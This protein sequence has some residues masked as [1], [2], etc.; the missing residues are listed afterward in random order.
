[1]FKILYK[2]IKKQFIFLKL[3]DIILRNEFI[4]EI[5]ILVMKKRLCILFGG[6][7]TEYEIS[8]RSAYSVITNVDT[9][10]YDIILVG[11]TRNGKWCLYQGDYEKI[12]NDSWFSPDLPT[13]SV[14]HGNKE[15]AFIVEKSDSTYE[16][17]YFDVIFPV[18]HGKNGEDGTIQGLFELAAI[19]YAG[20][21]IIASSVG[22]DKTF[23]KI[24]FKHAGIDQADWVEIAKHEYDNLN[25]KITEIETKLGYP[26]FIK[27]ANAGSSIGI[28]KAYNKDQLIEAI[29]EAFRFDRKILV[30]EL[31]TGHEVECA[32]LGNRGH[33]KA[34]CVGEIVASKDFYTYD[35]KY[36]S[37]STSEIVIPAN[38]E[39]KYAEIVRENAIKAFES[40]DGKGLSRVDFFVDEKKGRVC[41]N[42]INT[43][44]GFTSIS[45]YPKL[46]VESGLT[47]S[48]LLNEIIDIALQE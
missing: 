11:I 39:S 22:M 23:T 40:L 19:K 20:V 28:G 34:S 29:D 33:I 27:P 25:V 26:V 8:L 14:L 13:V 17:L 37:D 35:E 44:P 15:S 30:E 32:V 42:E 9:S 31:L 38:I 5:K 24:I 21:G 3:C 16:K 4:K 10:L 1:M 12:I 46:F 43:M 36:S 2:N 45:M 7:S 47:Y 18:L 41:I 6:E 48:Q